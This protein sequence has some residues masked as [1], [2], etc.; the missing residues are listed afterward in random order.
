VLLENTE[1]IK[2]LPHNGT[3]HSL[4]HGPGPAKSEAVCPDSKGGVQLTDGNRRKVI[5]TLG[6][7]VQYHEDACVAGE[8]RIM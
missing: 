7:G 4:L 8:D 5:E 3:N 1:Q 2:P 6:G